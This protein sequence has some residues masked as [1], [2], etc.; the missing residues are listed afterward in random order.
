M[1]W[2]A[3]VASQ[4]IKKMVQEGIQVKG[5]RVLVLGLTFKE[6]T[7]DFRNTKVVDVI[8]ELKEYGV[9][10]DVHD[11]MVDPAE[12]LAGYGIELVSLPD[13]GVYDAILLAVAHQLFQALR[14][15]EYEAMLKPSRVIQ[16][17]KWL[18]RA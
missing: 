5:S 3:Y 11:P 15:Q 1:R 17:L 9:Q 2:G 8:R 12:A 16:D 14:R 7:P 4:M 6:N 18:L 13:D 10:V